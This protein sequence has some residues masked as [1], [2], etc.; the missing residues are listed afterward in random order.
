MGR[1]WLG[2]GIRI[3]VVACNRLG[4]GWAG[5]HRPHP[6]LTTGDADPSPSTALLQTI[7]LGHLGRAQQ[8]CCRT[9]HTHSTSIITML[10]C[11]QASKGISTLRVSR[12][13][14]RMVVQAVQMAAC[15]LLRSHC[16]PHMVC[17]TLQEC[18]AKEATCRTAWDM[19]LG[20]SHV[21]RTC[22]G[23]LMGCRCSLLATLS[24]CPARQ[25][26]LEG[27]RSTP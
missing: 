4:L 13:S 24:T 7:F 20:I 9:P 15:V 12:T 21:L 2:S 8:A 5:D 10:T 11:Q 27:A 25:V 1:K 19:R 14:G 22:I 16:R 18:R 3:G 23:T 6:I 26:Q 17:V